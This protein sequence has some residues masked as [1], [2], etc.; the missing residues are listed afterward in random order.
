[1]VQG[2][3][4]GLKNK[5]GNASRHAAKAASST[6]KGQRYA[7]PK[8]AAAVK[9]AALHKVRRHLNTFSHDIY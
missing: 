9:S 8:K 3:T 6:K 4:K 1:M 7:A 5:K 2:A